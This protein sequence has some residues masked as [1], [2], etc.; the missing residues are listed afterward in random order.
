MWFDV[1][2]IDKVYAN[3]ALISA[4][5]RGGDGASFPVD[6]L[7]D[8]NTEFRPARVK[9][10]G[11]FRLYEEQRVVTTILESQLSNF[12]FTPDEI[13]L[14]VDHFGVPV[15]SGYY[16]MLFPR[17]W[18]V[19]EINVYDPYDQG[20]ENPA[21]KKSF[22]DVSLVWDSATSTSSA[23]F[24][25]QSVRRGT[26][27]LGLI[28]RLAPETA[29]RDWKERP[30][31]LRVEF[32]N[33]GHRGSPLSRDYRSATDAVI[34]ELAEDDRMPPIEVGTGGIN[35]DLVAWGRYLRGRFRRR[36]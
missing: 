1:V 3:G 28:A 14:Q 21:T 10:L 24:N 12:S 11:P 4:H 7:E 8:I 18:R 30:G 35:A 29:E 2:V 23:Q 13:L 33:D 27:S 9:D 22:R 5:L 20:S 25:M 31:V 26:F 32:T 16:A 34:G 17:G 36:A 19:L 6:R 15:K